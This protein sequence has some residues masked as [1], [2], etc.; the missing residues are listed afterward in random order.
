METLGKTENV[1]VRKAV[2][3]KYYGLKV[4]QDTLDI[5]KVT[6]Q[7][8]AELFQLTDNYVIGKDIALSAD[9]KVHYHIHFK[10]ARTLEA[11]QKYK[12]KVMPDW[13]RTTKLYPPKDRVE[14]V[15]CWYGYAV[16]E[17]LVYASPEI[18]LELLKLEQHTQAE[19]K[20]SQL[21]WGKQ[22][23]Q[24][25]QVKKDLETTIYEQ[26]DKLPLNYDF[27]NVAV[28]VS[29][30][31]YQEVKSLPIRSQIEKLVWKYLIDRKH[32][33]YEDYIIYQFPN[34]L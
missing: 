17:N 9:Q 15:M 34:K 23:E 33:D 26:L 22:Q 20:K 21:N 10:D 8:V 31:Y 13:G 16:K 5:K 24:K 1:I 28:W 18:D 11:L 7:E 32:K 27:F 30:F 6:I 14:N 29:K 3:Y 2:A 12:Q 4:N 25:K 19:F